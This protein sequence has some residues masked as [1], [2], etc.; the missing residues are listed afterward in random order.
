MKQPPSLPYPLIPSSPN[1]SFPNTFKLKYNQVLETE[2][3][4]V[5]SLEGVF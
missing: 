4:L 3:L 2:Q 5:G 1:C